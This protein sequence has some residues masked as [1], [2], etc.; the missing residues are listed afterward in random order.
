MIDFS[1]QRM[2]QRG[3][4]SD[5]VLRQTGRA[6]VNGVGR[7]RGGSV[8]RG[9]GRGRGTGSYYTRGLSYDDEGEPRG[10]RESGPPGLALR[11]GSL[12]LY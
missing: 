6:P 11:Y 10:V 12:L 1:L 5:A 7:G 4:N 2:W 8:D 9:R 3:V